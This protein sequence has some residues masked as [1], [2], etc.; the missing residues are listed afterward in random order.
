MAVPFMDLGWQWRQIRDEVMPRLELLFAA[1]AF[2]LG[3]YVEE[4]EQ[5]FAAWLGADH[6][7]ALDSG[8]AA[9]H[10]A[11]IA[12]GIGPGDQVLVP[13]N[14]F[15]A[16]AWGVVYVGA[17][18]IFCDVDAETANIDVADAA[19]RMSDRVKAII[20]VHLFGQPADLAAVEAFAK[21]HDLVL[22][23]DAAQAHGARY[24]GGKVGT[25]G[26]MGC[27]SFYPGKNLGAAGEAGA[28][29]T[30][31][32]QVAKRLRSL[33]NQ[34]QSHRYV[35]EEIGFNYRMDG[36]QGLILTHKLR[37][38]DEWTEI[39]RAIAQTYLEELAGLPLRLPVASDGHVHHLFVIRT[40]HRDELMNALQAQGIQ[41]GLHYPIPLHRQPCFSHIGCNRDSLPVAD[42]WAREGLS[43]PLFVGMT[44][45][46]LAHVISAVRAFFQ[47]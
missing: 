26:K 18:P 16:T 33:R 30:N 20:A 23:E 14:T 46:Q 22:V 44:N 6:V 12:A 47:S 31:D 9:L 4:F 29:A 11:M 8:T 1:S 41:T 34:A 21:A 25:F 5:A 37:R 15:I 7:V 40:P 45:D 28:I 19:R 3:P 10:L 36:I 43:L 32:H 42:N 13:A 2:S 35:H 38:L 24:K 39:R 17:T 27:F